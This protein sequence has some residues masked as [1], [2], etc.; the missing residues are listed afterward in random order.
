VERMGV[1]MSGIAKIEPY[2]L[3]GVM[4]KRVASIHSKS[5]SLILSFKM[6]TAPSAEP[7]GAN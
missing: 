6:L 4:L 7:G 2:M 1:S 3:A 5:L